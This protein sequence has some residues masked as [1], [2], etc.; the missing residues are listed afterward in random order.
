MSNCQLDRKFYKVKKN[1]TF[2][3]LEIYYLKM[4]LENTTQGLPQVG[5]DIGGFLSGL[6]PGLV[7]FLFTM[8]IALGIIGII[9]A[10]IYL[11]KRYVVKM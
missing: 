11:I 10:I 5:S 3:S 7:D 8:G 2:I 6:S 4:A 1:N 9:G